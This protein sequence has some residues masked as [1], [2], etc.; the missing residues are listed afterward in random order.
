[1]SVIF[2]NFEVSEN[3]KGQLVVTAKNGFTF[4]VSLLSSDLIGVHIN[5]KVPGEIMS[6]WV[7][8]LK[9]GKATGRKSRSIALFQSDP[10]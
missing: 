9:V 6:T 4:R 8:G 5:G 10:Q 2:K 3:E 7:S 1:M